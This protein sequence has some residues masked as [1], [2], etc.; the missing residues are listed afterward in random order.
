MALPGTYDFARD[1][2]FQGLGA[3]GKP[4]GP[5]TVVRPGQAHG[6]DRARDALRAHIEQRLPA[7]PAGIAV[8]LATGNQNAVDQDDADA[9]RRSGLTHLLSVSGLHIAAA[10]AFAMFL[11]LK[12]LAGS[13]F[14]STSFSSRP[15]P[16]PRGALAILC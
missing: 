3:V 2:W 8:A 12:L 4:L 9:M 5:V 14:A 1:A 10:V 7:S 16:P 13:R 6:L 15:A 11:S